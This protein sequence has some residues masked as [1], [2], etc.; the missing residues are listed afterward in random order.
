MI[1]NVCVGGWGGGMCVLFNGKHLYILTDVECYS[2]F[3]L[4]EFCIP[5]F[6]SLKILD[7][8]HAL[9]FAHITIFLI[10]LLY[11]WY[12]ILEFLDGL[13]C[14]INLPFTWVGG[15]LLHIVTFW[16]YRLFLGLGK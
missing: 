16:K 10:Y 15:A 4:F 6:K 8:K 9:S 14:L 5:L 12:L 11:G 13:N 7:S 2:F 3:V 1:V